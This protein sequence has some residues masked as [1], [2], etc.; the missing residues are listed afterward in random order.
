MRPVEEVHGKDP[1]KW[2]FSVAL[3]D[4][5]SHFPV[6]AAMVA[7]TYGPVLELGIGHYST[8]MLH[9]M[10][11]GRRK[12]VSVETDCSWLEN[13]LWMESPDH[14][15]LHTP[16]DEIGAMRELIHT[17]ESGP[18]PYWSVA[19]IDHKPGEAR[20]DSIRYFGASARY[21]V[22]HDTETDYGTA[23]DYKYEPAFK[24]FKYRWDYKRYRPYTT[25]VSNYTEIGK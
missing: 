6:L 12:L 19:F 13:F 20:A 25:V 21:V 2:P 24:K 1:K 15:F 23:A 4:Y 17:K 18:Q 7:R 8:P 16:E 11:E 3:G 10:C 9:L 14:E 22:V 5:G